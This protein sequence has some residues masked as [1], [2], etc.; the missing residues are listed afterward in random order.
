[1]SLQSARTA[2]E[3]HPPVVSPPASAALV[4]TAG[5]NQRLLADA[6]RALSNR[7]SFSMS[8]RIGMS[9]LLCFLLVV[10]V[11][12]AALVLVSRVG[13]LQEFLDKMSAYTIEVEQ[14]RRYQKNYLLYGTGLDEAL[15]QV[16]AAHQQLRGAK[17]SMIQQV[18][19]RRLRPH[20]GQPGAIQP[21]REQIGA[22]SRKSN[23][24]QNRRAE[25]KQGLRR[26]GAQLIADSTELIVRERLR[27]QTAIHTS[28][29]VAGRSLLL[30]MLTMVA[31]TY[32]LTRQVG[33][34]LKRFVGYPST[35]PTAISH[36]SFPSGATATRS[37]AD[38]GHQSH[39]VPAQAARGTT[40]SHQSHG[41]RGNY[42]QPESLTS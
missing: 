22:L 10:G 7:P 19:P 14:A 11:V 28:W 42:L 1:M 29:I 37:R 32:M 31:V 39:G 33:D 8:L 15:S 35:L 16:Q 20:A 40:G 21:V 9:M 3:L 13:N 41:R 30:I 4:G 38:S 23:S 36:P 18:G 6:E 27:L 25:I 5:E 17:D 34:P 2:E 12:L 26:Q 24:K